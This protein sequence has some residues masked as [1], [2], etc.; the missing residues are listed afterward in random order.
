[1]V[2]PLHPECS[3]VE[4]AVGIKAIIE[5]EQMN[6]LPNTALINL[7]KNAAL[8]GWELIDT[9]NKLT[10]HIMEHHKCLQ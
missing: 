1:M 8:V 10:N 2:I 6:I 9:Q 4:F 7:L 3:L 5:E